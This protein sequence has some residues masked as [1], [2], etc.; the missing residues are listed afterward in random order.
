VDANPSTLKY[1]VDT[2]LLPS[3]AM[4]FTKPELAQDRAPLAEKLFGIKGVVS[5][6]IGTNSSPSRR[7]T[8]ASG[9][10]STTE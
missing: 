1:V 3:G 10:S 5:V 7:A 4:N 6:M 2:K 9:T 8:T